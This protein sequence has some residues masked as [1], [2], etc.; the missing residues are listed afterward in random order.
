VTSA[1]HLMVGLTLVDGWKVI[2]RSE[3]RDDRT[4]AEFS[5]GYIVENPA[6]DRAF[7]KA[8]DW[9]SAMDAEN[10][11][12]ALQYLS[13]AYIFERDLLDRCRTSR[14]RRVVH[15]IAD[16]T[17]SVP[18]AKPSR[19][20]YLIFDEADGDSRDVMDETDPA[21][22]AVGLALV[23]DCAVALGQLHRGKVA[24]Q[25]VKPANLLGW[26]QTTGWS[27]KLADLGRAFCDV[28]DGPHGDHPCPGDTN[29]AAPEVLY[30]WPDDQA[31]S[32]RDRQLA[33]LFSLGSLLCYVLVRLPY[34]AL[35]EMELEREHQWGSWQGGYTD[36][37]T[38]LIDAHEHATKRVLEIV[39]IQ[40]RS[41][42]EELIND[43]CDPIVDTRGRLARRGGHQSAFLME[44]YIS[45]LD[46]L[47]KA[48]PDRRPTVPR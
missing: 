34:G 46:R 14:M 48:Y 7:C 21:D 45:R 39:H 47:A 38:V 32:A 11:A 13:N 27:A 22:F 4:S 36:A 5:V 20:S 15:A 24:H 40:I 9:S 41:D 18:N 3:L 35:L 33:D 6:G 23:R 2:E 44:R 10:V 8:L 37:R 12:E 28:I 19:V 43:M 25:D 16:G 26:R 29:W 31:R 42:V 17:V 1:A 30:G